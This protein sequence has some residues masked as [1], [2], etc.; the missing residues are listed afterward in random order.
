M[1]VTSKKIKEIIFPKPIRFPATIRTIFVQRLARYRQTD[2]LILYIE[3]LKFII[4]IDFLV[5]VMEAGV[6]VL[7]ANGEMV[8]ATDSSLAKSKQK[9]YVNCPMSVC[10]LLKKFE[11]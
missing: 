1:G 7:H 11:L 8:L 4:K 6:P 10:P 5:S 9:N 2:F 3:C